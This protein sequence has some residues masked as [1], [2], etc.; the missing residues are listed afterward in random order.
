MRKHRKVLIFNK[1]RKHE[2]FRASSSSE[3]GVLSEK[4]YACLE[5]VSGFLLHLRQVVENEVGALNE[6]H[7]I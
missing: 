5:E 1:R 3:G 4:Q 6:I 2:S 7:I